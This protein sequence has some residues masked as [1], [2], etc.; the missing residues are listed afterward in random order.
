MFAQRM[1]LD[2]AEQHDFIV[3]LMKDRVQMY[4]RI[5]AQPGHQLDI[6]SR[7]PA[8]RFLQS[9]ALGIFADGEKNL[10]DGPFDAREIDAFGD[11]LVALVMR[12]VIVNAV[13]RLV[14]FLITPQRIRATEL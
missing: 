9:L 6:R 4:P 12:I 10:A 14:H 1:K 11:G 3:R 13:E 8:R 2:V 7:D 5:D